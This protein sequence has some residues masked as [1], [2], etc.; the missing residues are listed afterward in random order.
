MQAGDVIGDLRLGDA[1]TKPHA[2]QAVGFGEA[3]HDDDVLFFQR[4]LNGIGEIRRVDEMMVDLI[5]DHH[6]MIRQ[7]AA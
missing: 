4:I 6:H 1:I 2:G 7:A 3:V 5:G